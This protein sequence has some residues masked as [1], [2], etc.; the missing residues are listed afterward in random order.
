MLMGAQS[1]KWVPG[2]RVL[3]HYERSWL[4]DDLLAGVVLTAILIPAGIGY[5]QVSGL[6]PV[7][8]LYA[9]IVPLLVYALVGPSRILVLGPDSSLAP[10]VGA[11]I[12]PL[13]AGDPDRAIALAG[14]LAILMGAFLVL[15]SV[16]RLGFVTDLLSKPIRIGYL[17]GLALVVIVGQLPGLLGFSVDADDLVGDARGVLSAIRDGAVDPIS[18][19]IGFGSIAVIL[20]LRAVHSRVPGVLVAVGGS[21]LLVAAAGWSDEIPVVGSL[22]SGLPAPALGGLTW[23]DVGS[24]LGPALGVSLIAF[25][26]TGVMSR[27][28]AARRGESV[29]GNDEMRALGISNVASGLFGGFS[30]SGS[31][32][33]T[34]VAEHAGARTQVTGVTGALMLVAFIM[35]VPD[36]TSYLPTSAL[37]AVVIVAASSFVDVPAVVHLLRR[38]PIEGMLSLAAF[39]GVAIIGV[40]QGIVVALG[41]S[42]VAFVNQAWRPYRTE[43][44]QI[45]GVRGYHD[46]T[47]H[48]GARRIDEIAIVR[49]DAPLFF[50]NAGIFA[51]FVRS[52]ADGDPS[53]RYLV[54]AAEPITSID[55]TAV[56]ELV[57]LDEHLA[58]AGIELVIA[59]LKGPVRDD[60]AR[61]GLTDRFGPDRFAPTVGAAVDAILGHERDDIGDPS[62][63]T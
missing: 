5:A 36:L 41:L 30:V 50:A 1:G 20:V 23:S 18:A 27:S 63:R 53:L 22:P 54:L 47:R 46:L 38:A 45:T 35:L 2:L 24:L 59:E 37:A 31:F 10:I 26:D 7:T 13:A 34:P 33:R 16:F 32:S 52:I 42:I 3:A 4:R 55:S 17:N 25:A 9:T 61:Y 51:H 29:E 58:S 60:L 43:L 6:A 14:L 57:A 11:S 15:G 48:S 28:M 44:G 19:A 8:G 56:D 39:A 40:L 12:L 62:D 49:F 21:M